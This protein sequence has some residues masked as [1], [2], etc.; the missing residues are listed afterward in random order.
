MARNIAYFDPIGGIAGD[1]T[2]AAFLDAGVDQDPFF[3]AIEPLGIRRNHL[4]IEEVKRKSARSLLVTPGDLPSPPGHSFT[5]LRDYLLS[6]GLDPAIEERA[7]HALD[8]IGSAEASFHGCDTEDVSFEEMA[9]MDFLLDLAGSAACLQIADIDDLLFPSIPVSRG[10]METHHGVLP[11]PAP[12]TLHLLEGYQIHNS[13]QEMEVTTPTGAAI[14]TTWGQQVD[15]IPDMNVTTAGYGAGQR[16]Q[17]DRPNCLRVILGRASSN[18]GT[19]SGTRDRVIQLET[20]L[21]DATGEMIGY[22][23]DSLLEAG[24]LDVQVFPGTGKH[25]RPLTHLTVL[26]RPEDEYRIVRNLFQQTTTFGIRRQILERHVMNRHFEELQTEWG[27]VRIK[28]GTFDG[29]EQ[30]S[31]EYRDCRKIAERED[32]SLQKVYRRVK[33]KLDET[34]N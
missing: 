10:E 21:D 26:V 28:V 11:A 22:V 27:P 5:S 20:T 3:S 16:E 24:V 18:T 32:I 8:R 15:G 33:K 13:G 2:L 4:S 6:A 31:P 14:V 29:I 19:E 7:V 9:G 34:G 1:M 17:P 25:S 23:V 12:A 30:R